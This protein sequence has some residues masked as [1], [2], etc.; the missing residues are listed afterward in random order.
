MKK[1]AIILSIV[2]TILVAGVLY[3]NHGEPPDERTICLEEVYTAP[4]PENMPDVVIDPM[5]G[6]TIY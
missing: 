1:T 4:F 5:T 3:G 6:F 2:C